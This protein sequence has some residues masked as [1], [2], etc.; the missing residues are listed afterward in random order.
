MLVDLGFTRTQLGADRGMFW[1]R[2][3]GCDLSETFPVT[4]FPV[5]AVL[6]SVFQHLL[7]FGFHFKAMLGNVR[8]SVGYLLIHEIETVANQLCRPSSSDIIHDA[9]ERNAGAS[10]RQSTARANDGWLGYC[11]SFHK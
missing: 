3:Q 1:F 10:N 7:I 2:R 9:I 5:A 11:F 4:F 6:F 8:E